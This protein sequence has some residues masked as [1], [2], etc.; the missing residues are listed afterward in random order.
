MQRH[1]PMHTN[2]R[3]IENEIKES[4]EHLIKSYELNFKKQNFV[5]WSWPFTRYFKDLHT[6]IKH[7]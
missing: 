5:T 6:S 1:P 4:K 7:S 3:K 2:T